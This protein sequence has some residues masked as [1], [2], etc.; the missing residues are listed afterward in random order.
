MDTEFFDAAGSQTADYGAK[1]LTPEAVVKT[2]LATLD[3]RSAPPSVITN[4]RPLALATKLLPRRQVVQIMGRMARRKQPPAS[5]VGS[6]RV[7]VDLV[8]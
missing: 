2:A 8:R 4:G 5:V 7:A 1:R 3:R 6:R